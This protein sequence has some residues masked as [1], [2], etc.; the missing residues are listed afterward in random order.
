M[1]ETKTT[2]SNMALDRFGA[3]TID[4]FDTDT[5]TRAVKSR[6]H[7]DQTRLALLES[8]DWIFAGD[9]VT[10][11]PH[12][13]SP[14]FEW[15]NKFELPKDYLTFRE[16][17][18]VTESLRVSNRWKIEGAFILS[19][20]DSIELV[21]TRDVDDPAEFDAL[22]IEILV[23]TMALKMIYPIAGTTS[24]TINMHKEIKE[25]LKSAMSK[26]RLIHKKQN[27]VSGRSDWN[28][29]RYSS[30]SVRTVGGNVVG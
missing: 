27:N 22:F 9:R 17:Q 15:D 4:D 25:D 16:D 6:L 12:P 13:E 10:L 29:A 26:A 18:T 11:S 7:Y 20:N 28:L 1:A 19:N 30:G 14:A 21:Y 3:K 24:A 5:N 23:L 2:I 8:F